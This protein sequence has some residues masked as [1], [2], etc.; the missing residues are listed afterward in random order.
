[1]F[2]SGVIDTAIGL[3]FVF[4][5]V[6]MLVTV[7]NEMISAFFPVARESGCGSASSASWARSGSTISTTIR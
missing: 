4:L 7:V 2:G 3:V 1:M 6:S 5:L